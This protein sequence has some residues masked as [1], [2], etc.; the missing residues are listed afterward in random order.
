M[1]QGLIFLIFFMMSA[2]ASL[3]P[4]KIDD[5]HSQKNENPYP[6]CEIEF[7]QGIKLMLDNKDGVFDCPQEKSS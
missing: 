7:E 5:L 4:S 1:K 6:Y 3:A 2:L